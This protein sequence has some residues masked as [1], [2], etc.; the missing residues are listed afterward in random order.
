MKKISLRTFIQNLYSL[1]VYD[2]HAHDLMSSGRI[3]YIEQCVNNHTVKIRMLKYLQDHPDSPLKEELLYYIEHIEKIDAFPYRTIK[4]L[5]HIE[6]GYDNTLSLPFIVHNNRRLFFP[7][8][9]KFEKMVGIYRSLIEEEQILEGGYMEKAPHCYQTEQ[10]KINPGDI[11]VDAGAAE[12]LFTLHNIDKVSHAFLIEADQGWIPALEATFEPWKDKVRI[13]NK[14]IG[15]NSK[16]HEESITLQEIL[17]QCQGRCFVKMDIEGA[18]SSAIEESL[19]YLKERK[20][21]L[22]ACCTYHYDKDAERLSTLFDKIG[23]HYEFSDGWFYHSY[24]ETPTPPF[25]RH[26][27]IRASA[28]L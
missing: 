15:D 22:L 17:S 26:A 5:R 8:D 1:W 10:F 13:I 21:C 7:H 12:G 28:T 11:L 20:D 6:S 9:M 18:E 23:Y 27:L 24:Y 25:L 16:P 2:F 14:S 19:A 3:T 4:R